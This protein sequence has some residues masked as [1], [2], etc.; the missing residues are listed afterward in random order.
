MRQFISLL[1]LF[2]FLFEYL[3][4]SL[5]T[6]YRTFSFLFYP[7]TYIYLFVFCLLNFCLLML[8]LC[9]C[10]FFFIPVLIQQEV[11]FK[12]P[13]Y[14]VARTMGTTNSIKPEKQRQLRNKGTANSID[15]DFYH[16]YHAFLC[17]LTGPKTINGQK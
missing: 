3:H 7:N 14:L 6:F 1:F 4:L 11:D 5:F 10:A 12:H 17:F 15:N 8:L 13:F 2:S 9:L 16:R